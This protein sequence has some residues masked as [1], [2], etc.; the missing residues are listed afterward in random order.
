MIGVSV[1]NL[2][3]EALGGVFNTDGFVKLLNSFDAMSDEVDAFGGFF[4]GLSSPVT[5][6]GVTD[7]R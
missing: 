1:D 5:P 4:N 2:D 7:E 6:V 3:E